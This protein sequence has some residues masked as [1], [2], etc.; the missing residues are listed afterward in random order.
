MKDRAAVLASIALATLTMIL[1]FATGCVAPASVQAPPPT[2]AAATLPPPTVPPPTKAPPTLPPPTEA[3]PTLPPPTEAPPTLPP[4]TE[5]PPTNPPPTEP[6]PTPAPPTVAPAT[7]VP[8]TVAPLPAAQPI[9]SSK[10]IVYAK[11][12]R[13]DN[14]AEWNQAANAPVEWKLDEYAPTEPGPWPAAVLV[15]WAGEARGEYTWTKLAEKLAGQGARVY[16]IDYPDYQPDAAIREKGRGYREMADAVACAVRFARARAAETGSDPV[17]VALAGFCLGGGA[18][19]QVAV[20]GDSLDSKWEAYAS[21]GGPPRQVACE[22]NE[23]STVV[24]VLVGSGGAY[25]VFLGYD[26]LYDEAFRQANNPEMWKMFQSF[27]GDNPGLKVRLLHSQRDP[28]MPYDNSVAAEAMLKNAGLDA[29]VVT[30]KGFHEMPVDLT[31][32]TVMDLLKQP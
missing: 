4:P 29:E 3:P 9:T 25:D 8:A 19:S 7:I 14:P 12:M 15:N 1:V 20:A 27:A 24:D 21:A 28:I 31:V 18:A 22:A 26:G 17:R 23:G 2:V 32:Q 13:Q 10:D 30:F 16:V 11:G 5:P 6:L